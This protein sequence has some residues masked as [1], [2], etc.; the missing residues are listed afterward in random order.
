VAG[1]RIEAPKGKQLMSYEDAL[2]ILSR[3]EA[4][5]ATVSAMNTLL[6][7]KG[8]YAPEEFEFQFR[9][10]AQRQIRK[11]NSANHAPSGA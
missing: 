8:V 2:E 5:K 3:D 7:A 10:A 1:K 11:R 4:F 9:Q 6:L